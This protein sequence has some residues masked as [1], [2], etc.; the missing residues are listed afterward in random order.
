MSEST[1]NKLRYLN[2]TKQLIRQAIVNKGQSITDSTPFRDYADK[3]T[4]IETGSDTSDAT[5]TAND[6]LSPETAYVNNEKIIGY[7][8]NGIVK[9]DSNLISS[10]IAN[11]VTIFGVQGSLLQDVPVITIGTITK[12]DKL[13]A[14]ITLTDSNDKS[15]NGTGNTYYATTNPIYLNVYVNNTKYSS[16]KVNATINCT[17][18]ITIPEI[19]TLSNTFESS[20]ELAGYITEVANNT[21]GALQY[22]QAGGYTGLYTD[23]SSYVRYNFTDAFDNYKIEFDFYKNGTTSYSRV[24]GIIGGSYELE[25]KGASNN[26]YF[27]ADY[28]GG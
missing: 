18:N 12:P 7:I 14:T 15:L 3:I 16:T 27:G 24:I 25:I 22:T 28:D 10:N 4:N 17:I 6:I 8:N 23:G 20:Y 26:I 21:S 1:D 5:A 11:G 13:N 19:P 2:D 9:G